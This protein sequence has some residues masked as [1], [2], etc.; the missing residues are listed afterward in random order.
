V[1]G[2]KVIHKHLGKLLIDGRER[3]LLSRQQ[4]AIILGFNDWRYLYRCEKGINNFPAKK[5]K[6]AIH[7]YK[8][9][10]EDMADAILSDVKEGLLLFFKG[11]SK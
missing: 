4:A 10:H 2:I 7:V 11:K 5:L 9:N 8:L 3:K 1:R 6:R